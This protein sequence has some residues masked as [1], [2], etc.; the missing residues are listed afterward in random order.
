MLI[1]PYITAE[2][3]HRIIDSRKY[4]CRKP[5]SVFDGTFGYGRDMAF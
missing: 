2:T 5:S 4:L 3:A 1:S